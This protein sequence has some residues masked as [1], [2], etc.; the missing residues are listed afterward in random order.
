MGNSEYTTSRE[1]EK[2]KTAPLHLVGPWQPRSGPVR[3]TENTTARAEGAGGRER[4]AWAI[5]G[6]T[7]R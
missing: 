2:P 1:K 6:R 3:T 5:R 4:S 7:P